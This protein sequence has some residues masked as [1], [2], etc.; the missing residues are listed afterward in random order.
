M[1]YYTWKINWKNHGTGTSLMK[2]AFQMGTQSNIQ[3]GEAQITLLPWDDL[4]FSCTEQHF[5]SCLE[6]LH[7]RFRDISKDPD[8]RSASPWSICSYGVVTH[9]CLGLSAVSLWTFH[10]GMKENYT[11]EGGFPLQSTLS[12]F[13][14]LFGP[15]KSTYK[16][17]LW[18][19]RENCILR[20]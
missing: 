11:K 12:G 7:C 10:R 13:L 9:S 2:T 1:I 5:H 6:K 3:P 20:L 14:S 17:P 18:L 8:W 16:F 15:T 4:L 19:S